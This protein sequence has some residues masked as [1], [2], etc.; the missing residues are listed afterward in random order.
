MHRAIWERDNSI[1]RI[2]CA[3]EVVLFHRV[4]NVFGELSGNV[5]SFETIFDVA[6]GISF[7][8]SL[9]GDATTAGPKDYWQSACKV[10][11]TIIGCTVLNSSKSDRLAEEKQNLCL[12]L[13]DSRQAFLPQF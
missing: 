1:L 12:R 8:E 2:A 6:S 4:R 5:S 3:Q 11:R 7:E 13:I 10:K 9:M